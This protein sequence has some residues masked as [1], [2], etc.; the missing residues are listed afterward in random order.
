MNPQKK[1]KTNRFYFS[2]C[3]ITICASIHAQDQRIE[4]WI[5][6]DS[7]PYPIQNP[8]VSENG[9][10]ITTVEQWEDI[11][12]P[13][14]YKLFEQQEYG[15]IPEGITVQFKE[16]YRSSDYLQG[17]AT[18][19]E[20]E[21]WINDEFECGRYDLNYVGSYEIGPGAGTGINNFFIENY[22]NNGAYKDQSR[23]F[24]NVVISRSRIGMAEL[25][26]E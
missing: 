15:E 23:Y 2:L 8:L 5:K 18:L 17:K 4:R 9:I 26:Y 3:I 14:L 7:I 12:R 21:M 1:Q 13:E 19:R 16:I 6:N 20:F 24:S 11:R 10:E 22:W 25:F